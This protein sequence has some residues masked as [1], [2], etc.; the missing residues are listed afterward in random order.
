MCFSA[1]AS[2]TLFGALV[3]LGIYSIAKAHQS[4]GGWV[5]FAVY[6][7]AFGLQQGLEG[8]VWLGLQDGNDTMVCVASRGY[9]F[10]SH[11]FWLAWVPFSVWMIETNPLRKRLL[12]VLSAIGFFYGLSIMVPSVL[13]RD[14]LHMELI[15]QSLEYN[16][17]LIYEGFINRTALR[18]FYAAIVVGALVLSSHRPVRI[19]A[20]LVAVSLAGTYVF[21][22]YAFISVWCFF[23]AILSVYL[24]VVIWLDA[25][26]SERAPG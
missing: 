19:F 1:T 9:L 15:N 16:T 26:R 21:F 24:V 13:L 11:F 20:G 12:A 18:L 23:A 8:F 7:L 6:P 14:W 4:K 3:P 22:A 25:R 2:F 5:P 17:T 10:F